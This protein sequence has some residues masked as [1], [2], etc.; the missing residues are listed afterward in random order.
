ML[1]TTDTTTFKL[2]HSDILEM[3]PFLSKPLEIEAVSPAITPS[4]KKGFIQMNLMES[5]LNS[6]VLISL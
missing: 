6:T 3:F 5:T 1:R 2:Q 4:F